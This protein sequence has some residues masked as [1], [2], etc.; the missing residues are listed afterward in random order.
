M[1]RGPARDKIRLKSFSRLFRFLRFE[2][3]GVYYRLGSG[4]AGQ[5]YLKVKILYLACP[6]SRSV[7][8]GCT[9]TRGR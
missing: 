4:D 3:G 8:V 6:T 1:T 9:R 7:Q 5:K 2:G